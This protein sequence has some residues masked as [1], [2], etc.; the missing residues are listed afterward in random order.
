MTTTARRSVLLSRCTTILSF[1]ACSYTFVYRHLPLDSELTKAGQED[2]S[3]HQHTP[4]SK[5]MLNISLL[6]KQKHWSVSSGDFDNTGNDKNTNRQAEEQRVTHLR[7][8]GPY[9]SDTV[10]PIVK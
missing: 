2:S 1:T 3:T 7:L 8:V 5:H 9:L 4:G 6:D 10:K